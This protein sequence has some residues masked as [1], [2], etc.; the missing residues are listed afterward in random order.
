MTSKIE[1]K[2]IQRGVFYMYSDRNIKWHKPGITKADRWGGNKHESAL[3]WIAGLSASGLYKKARRGD[4][5]DFTGIS[6]PYER[7]ASQEIILDTDRLGIAENVDKIIT[8][9]TESRII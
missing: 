7:P 8:C 6:Q 3:T 4:I 9:L 2:G 1:Y 5:S